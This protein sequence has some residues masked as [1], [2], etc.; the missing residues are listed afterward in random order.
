MK[1][2][3]IILVAL[4]LV[5]GLTVGLCAA[6]GVFKGGSEKP[7]AGSDSKNDDSGSG[8]ESGSG[9]NSPDTDPSGG[10]NMDYSKTKYADEFN[11]P[12]SKY[13]WHNIGHG[14]ASDY[15]KETSKFL[16]GIKE[17][18]SL[19][20]GGIVSNVPWTDAYVTDP[21]GFE[22]LSKAAKILFNNGLNMWIYDEKGYPS[23]QAGGYTAKDH[24]EYLAKGI[25]FEAKE[26]SGR[27]SVTINCPDDVTKIHSAYAVNAAGETLKADYTD[28]KATFAGTDGSWTFYVFYEK[29]LFEGTH[30]A[31]NG[32]GQAYY[33][34]LMDQNAVNAFIENTYQQYADK[35][36][37]FDKIVGVF[38][39]EPSLMEVYQNTSDTFKYSQLATVDGFEEKFEEMHGYSIADKYHLIF[40]GDSEEAKIVR[41]NYRE[42]VAEI[43]SKTYFGS[44]R[45]FCEKH[46]TKSSGHCLL[47]ESMNYHA[48]YYGNLMQ[49]LR[50][51]SIPGVDGLSMK[52]ENYLNEGW[53]IFMAVKYASSVATLTDKD[54]LVMMEICATDLP[55]SGEYTE[56]QYRQFKTTLNNIFFDGATHINSYVG[57]SLFASHTKELLTYLGRIAYMSRSAEW[58]GQV[59]VYYPIATVQAYTKPSYSAALSSNPSGGP[60]MGKVG[61]ALYKSQQDFTVV[62]DIFIREAK[63][64]NGKLYTDNVSFKVM[65]MPSVEIIPLDVMQK[66]DAFEKSGGTV[67]W[68]E[69]T[70][71]LA[72]KTADHDAVKALASGKNTVTIEQAVAQSKTAVA[73]KL[74]IDKPTSTLFVGRYLLEDAP[75]YWLVNNN[76]LEKVLTLSYEG[77]KGFDIYD[78][79]TGKITSVSG[80]SVQV[81]VASSSAAFVI[82]KF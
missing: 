35:F 58:D 43:L 51:M 17:M 42:T 36:E 71:E 47:E 20:V 63:A 56:D 49:C 37:Y 45:E 38:T 26:G 5:A 15:G 64:E 1:K 2:P 57:T 16:A 33:P 52:T 50:E 48:H 69:R 14:F 44:L 23:G 10:E 31:N 6:L 9:T 74:T 4:C 22:W 75:M 41:V 53:P 28:T 72:D 73:D 40:T 27:N 77:A 55:T 60:Q 59:G 12:S 8:S 54:R 29:V 79:E 67:I 18:K 78:P 61:M 82:V 76:S 11:N 34:N 81:T 70:P 21:V 66:L 25:V 62:D 68:I 65:I 3:V 19:G 39:D 80:N 7:P 32:S 13:R 24:P 46:G 30:A